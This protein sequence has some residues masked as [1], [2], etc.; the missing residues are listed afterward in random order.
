MPL[1]FVCENLLDAIAESGVFAGFPLGDPRKPLRHCDVCNR[2]MAAVKDGVASSL[3]DQL[4][5]YLSAQHRDNLAG[6]CAM[7]A[8][9]SEIGR[10]ADDISA[11]Y[12]EGFE[13]LVSIVEATLGA[14]SSKVR[15]HQRALVIVAAM[16]GGVAVARATAKSRRDLSTDVLAALRRVLGEVGG[17]RP[18]PLGRSVKRSSE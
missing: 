5:Y 4:D 16:I 14:T 6:G 13:Q 18:L 17:E 9:A 7:A 1:L 8:S 3:G 15:R 12:S 2:H 11:R 10:Q